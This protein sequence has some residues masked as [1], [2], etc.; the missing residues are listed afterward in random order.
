MRRFTATRFHEPTKRGLIKPF[1]ILAEDQ[2]TGKELTLVVK[3]NAGYEAH[4]GVEHMHR[5][6]YC[7]LLGRALG[8]DAVEPVAVDLPPGF[9]FGALDFKDHERTDY[10]KLITESHGVNFA[11]IHLGEDWMPWTTTTRPKKVPQESI[12]HSFSFDAMVQNDDR[13]EDNP[14][15]LWK[16]D[17]LVLLDFDRAWGFGYFEQEKQPWRRVLERLNLRSSSLYPHLKLSKRDEILGERLSKSLSRN[18]LKR[19]SQSCIDEVE[20]SF[21]G[22]KLDF[23]KLQRYITKLS[24]EPHDFF[25]FLT[26]L[27]QK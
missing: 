19:I 23:Q 15:L 1:L 9:E 16:S 3:S 14:N 12:N 8:L 21:P 5:E 22:A 10:H 26:V 20:A 13:K 17:R 4:G 6:A 11:T 18:K 25:Q 7:L 2:A 27:C 24:G